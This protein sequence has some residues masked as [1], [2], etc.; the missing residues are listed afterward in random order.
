MTKM[1]VAD[2]VQVIINQRQEWNHSYVQCQWDWT[3]DGIKYNSIWLTSLAVL[4]G[5]IMSR[6][7][8]SKFMLIVGYGECIFRI[9][10]IQRTNCRQNLNYSCPFK[11]KQN[12]DNYN[13]ENASLFSKRKKSCSIETFFF[14][15]LRITF[16]IKNNLLKAVLILYAA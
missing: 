2:F 11:I 12:V 1:Y 10:Y 13:E 14:K 9:D 5:Q 15:F 7:W 16:K 8:E 4:M 3:M 6:H